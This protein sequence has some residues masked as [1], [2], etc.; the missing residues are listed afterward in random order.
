MFTSQ[1]YKITDQI[2]SK[3]NNFKYFHIREKAVEKVYSDIGRI[4]KIKD[5]NNPN[6][7]LVVAGC[8]AQAEELK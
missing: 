8:V 6:M 5:K 3:L 7:K 4:K 2:R 1:G